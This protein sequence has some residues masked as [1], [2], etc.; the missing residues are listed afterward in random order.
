MEDKIKLALVTGAAGALGLATSRTLVDDGYRVILVD[1]DQN[2]LDKL[3]S[4]LGHLAIPVALDISDSQAVTDACDNIRKSHGNVSVLVNNAGV[5]SN[6]KLTDTTDEEWHQIMSVNLDGSFYLCREWLPK[7]KDQQW[8]RIINIGSLAMKT[9]GL[10]AG[11]TY[12]TS[13]GAIT[14][15]TLSIARESASFG[16]TANGIAPAYIMTPM[17]TDFLTEEQKSELLNQI[18]VG[19]FCEAEEVAHVVRFLASPL[20]GF[21]TGEIID[22]NGGLH[23]D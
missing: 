19:R 23:M 8:G 17:I 21:I 13:K 2:K 20:S 5:L 22:I 12:T 14:A 4:E 16:V 15:L 11:T 9:G 18:P 7:M 3:A 10:T 6:S 1:L